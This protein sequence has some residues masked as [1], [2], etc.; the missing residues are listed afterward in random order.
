MKHHQVLVSSNANRSR[1]SSAEANSGF[2]PIQ[3]HQGPSP[4]SPESREVANYEQY[5][6]REVPMFVRS[7]LETA[8]NNEVEPIEERL[9]AQIVSLIEEAQ[10]RA[11][12]SYRALHG[13]VES[14]V[15]PSNTSIE[16]RDQPNEMLGASSPDILQF[17]QRPPPSAHP[18]SSLTFP[19]FRIS[20]RRNETSDSGYASNNSGSGSSSSQAG[21]LNERNTTSSDPMILQPELAE[22]ATFSDEA[23]VVPDSLPESLW[24]TTAD[25]TDIEHF[26]CRIGT[27][28]ISRLC[29]F[30]VSDFNEF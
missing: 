19:D 16:L 2:Y 13:S 17:Y 23:P 29:S 8:V 30:Q 25:N 10:N 20:L 3:D 5:L 24:T 7:A 6:R 9:R 12:S 15:P 11:F 21:F 18:E 4:Q 22:S 27:M 28:G 26:G 14:S 1:A